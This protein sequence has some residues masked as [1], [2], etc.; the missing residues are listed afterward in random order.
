MRVDN[1][2]ESLRYGAAMTLKIT[3]LS[4]LLMLRHKGGASMDDLLVHARKHED[5]L[6]DTDKTQG[7][8]RA[9]TLCT[10]RSLEFMLAKEPDYV[11]GVLTDLLEQS[12]GVELGRF[13]EGEH[14][15]QLAGERRLQ[16]LRE[17][18]L[19]VARQ[20]GD[21]GLQALAVRLLLRL[22]YLYA[23]AQDCLLA[24]ELQAELRIDISWELQP[25][26]DRSEAYRKYAP[27][28]PPSS[29]ELGRPGDKQDVQSRV[30]FVGES[31][32]TQDQDTAI[33]DSQH[34]FMWSAERGLFKGE[35]K[36][37]SNY[38][39]D[40][41]GCTE[42]KNTYKTLTFVDI[43]GTIHVRSGHLPGEPFVPLDRETCKVAENYEPWTSEGDLL[44]WTSDSE[45]SA[46]GS[47]ERGYRYLRG[48]QMHYLDGELWVMASYKE[49]TWDSP[50]KQ[51]VVEVWKRENRH[52]K[53]AREIP[54]FKEDGT[55]RFQGAKR[56]HTDY[57][58]R[59]LLHKNSKYILLS[60][61]KTIYLFD[62]KTGQRV[63]KHHENS[64]QHVTFYNKSLKKF[65]WM[66]CACYSYLYYYPI[67]GY[68]PDA[69]LVELEQGDVPM[70][71][72]L[73][74]VKQSI[75]TQLDEANVEE[76]KAEEGEEVQKKQKRRD[77][78][79]L[80]HLDCLVGLERPEKALEEVPT[81]PGNQE[82]HKQTSAI[83]HSFINAEANYA[84]QAAKYY[85]SSPPFGDNMVQFFRASF[86]PALTR[87]SFD[88]VATRLAGALKRF[89]SAKPAS[90]YAQLEVTMLVHMLQASL[91]Q[92]KC[93][94]LNVSQVLAK[95]QIGEVEKLA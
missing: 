10:P 34:Y 66:D 3:T 42:V 56:R 36:A 26:L 85:A 73:D 63:S 46:V 54:L 13:Y 21:K 62:R 60:S 8:F 18:L 77:R 28:V 4:A 45:Q 15:N 20:G 1:N 5:D 94:R 89:D 76:V 90:T 75:R 74:E 80:R 22:G 65:S 38:W 39:D 57:A 12:R 2:E 61:G 93:C 49:S 59:G 70:P 24:A 14:L 31:D 51:C 6:S 9:L 17:L 23:S 30:T 69:Q 47:A 87:G 86:G 29:G 83:I 37:E 88:Y 40:S 52:F 48:A 72:L 71:V 50:I 27:P 43:D 84:Q 35:R 68:D 81:L 67:H 92:V 33:M 16:D 7:L 25:L 32:R 53:R 91:Y 19:V 79:P 55:T 95:E 41:A 64:T 58:N 44:N 78:R 11:R 82:V